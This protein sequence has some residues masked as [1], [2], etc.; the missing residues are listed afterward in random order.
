MCGCIELKVARTVLTIRPS[1]FD[2]SGLVLSLW[3]W[4]VD[5]MEC[6]NV[7]RLVYVYGWFGCR[8]A[9]CFGGSFN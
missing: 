8:S 1:Q 9:I 3:Y 4:P 7:S 6:N 2:E 5:T